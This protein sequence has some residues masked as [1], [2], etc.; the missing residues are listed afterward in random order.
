MYKP[1]Y[2]LLLGS[3]ASIGYGAPCNAITTADQVEF[4]T[5][6]S[7][8]GIAQVGVR[9]LGSVSELEGQMR[10]VIE[11]DMP[12][13]VDLRKYA[14][15]VM[16]EVRDKHGLRHVQLRDV[17]MPRVE[18]IPAKRLSYDIRCTTRTCK[19]AHTK[20]TTVSTTHSGTVGLSAEVGAKPFGV[21]VQFTA[22]VGYGFSKTDEESTA[23]T[24]EFEPSIEQSTTATIG[25]LSTPEYTVIS[26]TSL[27]LTD[28]S[29]MFM[30]RVS[31]LPHHS[32]YSSGVSSAA[33]SSLAC[34]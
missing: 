3:L 12:I 1:L 9:M 20:T 5:A 13:V 15:A 4:T 29:S 32:V 26:C 27:L 31:N 28:S 17:A 25:D 7:D 11:R 23:F 10:K 16:D 33:N 18:L 24:Y 30:E 14:F 6:P 22:S 8:V 19:I 21:G 2:L 34:V